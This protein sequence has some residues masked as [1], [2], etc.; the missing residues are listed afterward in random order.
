MPERIGAYEILGTIGQGASAV[1][2][3]AEQTELA[4]R[5]AL[6]ALSPSLRA[7][8]GF[9]ERFRHEA[10]V[11][12]LLDHPN[13]VRVWEFFEED[14]GAYLAMEYVPGASLRAVI[15]QA[16]RLS[17][18]Q[19][20]GVLRG[21]LSGLA[22][23]HGLGLTHRDLKPENII[24]DPEGTSKLVDFGQAIAPGEAGMPSGSSGTPAYMSPEQAR[25]EAGD[26]RSD[27]YAAS[28]IL[29]ELLTGE[30]PFSGESPL[31]LMRKHISEPVP[32]ARKLNRNLSE[33]VAALMGRGMAKEPGERFQTAAEFLAAL[34]EAADD[35]Y[36]AAWEAASSIRAL[37]GSAVAASGL[38]AG[39]GAGAS[40]AGASEATGAMT[41][42]GLPSS[43]GA[44]ADLAAVTASTSTA[45]AAGVA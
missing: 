15:K 30:P 14:A 22:H 21:A 13:C 42:A 20:L 1:V 43:A 29:Y 34:E 16:G 23:A 26:V 35:A 41:G 10:Q 24:A 31:A 44:A 36:G 2:Y 28:A 40:A 27:V 8:P 4:R 6:K 39:A 19:S 11:M 25:G 38:A 7:Q 9:I 5:V 45:P 37:V 33:R 17:P 3:L 18:E 12:A 32:D